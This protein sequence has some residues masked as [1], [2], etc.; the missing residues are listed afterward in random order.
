MIARNPDPRIDVVARELRR[1]LAVGWDA[2]RGEYGLMD[3]A[4]REWAAFAGPHDEKIDWATI[5]ARIILNALA[6]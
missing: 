3:T 4:T 6:Q 5:R 2:R 1:D